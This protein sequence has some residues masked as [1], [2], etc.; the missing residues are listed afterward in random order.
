MAFITVDLSKSR[1]FGEAGHDLD[2]FDKFESRLVR[3]YNSGWRVDNYYPRPPRNLELS[4]VELVHMRDDR[5]RIRIFVTGSIEY[6][7]PSRGSP[8]VFLISGPGAAARPDPTTNSKWTEFCKWAGV[9]C[10]WM[11]QVWK[12]ADLLH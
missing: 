10:D 9:A 8:I 2:E 12:A 3:L 1:N 6:K 4:H 11:D 7:D 5:K